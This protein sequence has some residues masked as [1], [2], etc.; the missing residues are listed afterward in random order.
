MKN[1]KRRLSIL[2]LALLL[3]TSAVSGTAVQLPEDVRY[4][5]QLEPAGTDKTEYLLYVERTDAAGIPLHAGSITLAADSSL[6]FEPAEGWRTFPLSNQTGTNFEI[7]TAADGSSYIGFYWYWYGDA[8]T[9]VPSVSGDYSNRQLLG[10]LEIASAAETDD[11]RLLP[12]PDTASGAA[13][14]SALGTASDREAELEIVESVWRMPNIAIPSEGYYQG[15]YAESRTDT[16]TEGDQ[17]AVDL[18]AGWMGFSIGAYAPEKPAE[19]LF[20][21]YSDD[22]T[23]ELFA[24]AE[25][26]FGS[27]TGHFT[28]RIEF[29][30]LSPKNPDTG[31]A[32]SLTDGYYDIVILKPSHVRCEIRKVNFDSSNGIFSELLGLHIELPCGDLVVKKAD[33]AEA[34]LRGDGV[35]SLKDRSVLMAFL[36]GVL[37]K[38]APEYSYADLNG[39]GAVSLSD[40]DILMS[41]ENYNTKSI[42]FKGKEAD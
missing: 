40:L 38:D 10:T 33:S 12:W 9:E 28:G 30:S 11:I 7:G 31:S 2:I 17:Y 20:Y 29:S 25:T 32:V 18:T 41:K 19:L 5:Y 13:R 24:I 27:G 3:L 21:K 34:Q 14:I 23:T 1:R 4:F 39:D 26:D 15:Y 42:I 37:T 6:S 16:D 36:N 35:I 22:G 8:D